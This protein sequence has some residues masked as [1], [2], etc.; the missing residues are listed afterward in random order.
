[1]QLLRYQLGALLV[2]GMVL[3]LISFPVG[4]AK[5]LTDDQKCILAR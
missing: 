1:M 5:A 4:E 2:G 3:G